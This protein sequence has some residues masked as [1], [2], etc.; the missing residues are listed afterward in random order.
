VTE[1]AMTDVVGGLALAI[2][3]FVAVYRV[4]RRTWDKKV[5][6]SALPPANQPVQPK[7]KVLARI[8]PA[9]RSP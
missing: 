3:L 5:V 4:T 8:E 6:G 7:A 1:I 9:R 2:V